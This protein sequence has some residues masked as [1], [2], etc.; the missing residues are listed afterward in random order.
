MITAETMKWRLLMEKVGDFDLVFWEG[1][2]R[3]VAADESRLALLVR[4]K[5]ADYTWDRMH[6]TW[7]RLQENHSL[8]VD[9][10]GGGHDAVGLVS[11]FFAVDRDALEALRRDGILRVREASGRPVRPDPGPL[12]PRNW[13]P[14]RRKIDGD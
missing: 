9:E 14:L 13:E 3:V 8:T 2:G 7:S 10:L 6:D 4:G 12:V 1:K 11:L 5:R